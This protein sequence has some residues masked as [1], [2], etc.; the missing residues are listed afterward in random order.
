MLS[1]KFPVASEAVRCRD[2]AQMWPVKKMVKK[3]VKMVVIWK[4]LNRYVSILRIVGVK[5]LSV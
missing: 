3:R 5:V 4:K 2:Q 1:R